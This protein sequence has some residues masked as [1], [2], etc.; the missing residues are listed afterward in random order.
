M[1]TLSAHKTVNRI[2]ITLFLLAIWLPLIGS[3][4]KW[5]TSSNESI[6][7][8]ESRLAAKMPDFQVSLQ[9]FDE[10]P[11]QFDA[12]Y[13]DFFGFRE[14]LITWNNY[15]VVTVFKNSPSPSVILGKKHPWLFYTGDVAYYRSPL[16]QPQE[17]EKL[18][19]ILEQRRDWLSSQ[20]IQYIFLVAPNKSS[21]YPEYLPT[22]IRALSSESRLDQLMD[23]LK[24]NS[25]LN[26][27]DL[28]QEF[29]E[30]KSSHRIYAKTDTH[31]NELGAFYAY[32]AVIQ[33]VSKKYPLVKPFELSDFSLQ[34]I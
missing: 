12:Y 23:Y 5:N 25:D 33:K 4:F 11:R 20:G 15:I 30:A 17:L 7:I 24:Q 28:R 29:R 18:K 34:L 32:R 9:Y 6:P 14:G 22:A 16:F 31:W 10:F 8:S 13:N 26:I 3:I 1:N 21:V 27:V 2:W 19:I